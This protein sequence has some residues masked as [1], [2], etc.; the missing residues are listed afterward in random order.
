MRNRLKILVYW[1]LLALTCLFA[2]HGTASAQEDP[3]GGSVKALQAAFESDKR[4]RN[5]LNGDEQAKKDDARDLKSAETAANWYIWRI[6]HPK[7]KEDSISKFQSDFADKVKEMMEKVISTGKPRN[8]RVFIDMFGRALVT[9]MKKVLERD[10]KRDPTTMIH[11]VMML[12]TMAKLKQD[13]VGDYLLELVK[14]G[15]THDVFRLYA[16]KALKEYMPIT[17]HDNLDI[18]S[19]AVML[20]LL[21]DAK[22][23]D[24]LS[25][26]ITRP[27]NVNGL[28]DGEIAAIHFLRRE[29][30][31]SL[32]HAGAPAVLALRKP[33]K[34]GKVG[35]DATGRKELEI[36][37]LVAP[38]LFRVLA[39][40]LPL[41]PTIQEKLEAVHG[42]CRIKSTN[43]SDYNADLAVYL[44]GRTLQEFV[45]EYNKDWANFAALGP[46]KT[47]SVVAWK[48]EAR[49]LDAS[50]GLLKANGGKGSAQLE[51]AAKPILANIGKYDRPDNAKVADLN[52]FVAQLPT[53]NLNAFKNIKSPIKLK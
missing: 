11:A 12:P 9:S 4:V 50:L 2:T 53:V 40:D 14:Q 45:S 16:L 36:E 26:Y 41:A 43:L 46:K 25:R 8:N 3:L 28:S 32:G 30:I 34:L 31:T 49:L 51:A 48:T 15:K 23:V 22:Y 38:T 44:V 52:A 39:N 37:G 24:V 7:T 18:D 10:I 29:A 47:L 19:K 13:D 5:L 21:R 35:M 20:G 17:G 6:T 27:V 33:L 42:V 1:C